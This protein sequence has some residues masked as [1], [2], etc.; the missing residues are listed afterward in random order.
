MPQGQHDCAAARV[1]GLAQVGP[2][3]RHRLGC[4]AGGESLEDG[5]VRASLPLVTTITMRLVWCGA[6]RVGLV[7]RG[8]L[9]CVVARCGVVLCGVV[10]LVSTLGVYCGLLLWASNLCV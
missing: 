10:G 2:A 1:G 5:D 7:R 9:W 4:G 8:V 3:G 6:V